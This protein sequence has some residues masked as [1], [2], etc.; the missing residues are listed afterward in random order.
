MNQSTADFLLRS[1]LMEAEYNRK[2]IDYAKRLRRRAAQLG[3][4][5]E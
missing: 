2:V 4:E 5:E 1:P 3:P